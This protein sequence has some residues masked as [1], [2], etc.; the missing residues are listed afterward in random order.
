M[1]SYMGHELPMPKKTTAAAAAKPAETHSAQ[2][3]EL[4][5]EI[6]N[7][8]DNVEHQDQVRSPA[9]EINKKASTDNENDVSSDKI[10][11]VDLKM[12][13]NEAA[14]AAPESEKASS[15]NDLD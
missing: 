3:Q 7:V 2:P 10:D 9:G 4:A 5:A 8:A 14:A 1:A 11:T 13:I 12:N 15:L 6:P